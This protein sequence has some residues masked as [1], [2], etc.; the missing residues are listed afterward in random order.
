MHVSESS[1]VP[2][3]C[4]CFALSDAKCPEYQGECSHTQDGVCD[5]CSL[6]EVSIRE[7]E[8]TLKVIVA[9]SDEMDELTFNTEQAKRSISAWKAHLLRAVNQD[10]A[11]VNVMEKLDENSVFLVQDWAMKFLPRKYRESQSDWFA[12]RGIPWHITVAL[13]QRPNQQLET[14]TFVHIFQTCSQDSDAVLGIMADVLTKLKIGMP[15]LESV[16]YRQDNAG[17]YHCASTIVGAKVVGDKAGVTLK[18]MDFS[19]PQGGKGA[20]DRK[21]AT[22]KSHMH[23]YLNEGNDIENAVQMKAAIE[24]SGGV[25]GVVVTLAEM[26]ESQAKKA[27]TLEGVSF[28]NN[29]QYE[30]NCLR[31]WRAYDIGP[32]KIISWSKFDALGV[33]HECYSIVDIG[34]DHGKSIHLPF[35]A[36]KPRKVTCPVE[37]ISSDGDDDES[38]SKDGSSNS[39]L[40]SCPEEGCVMTYQRHS[41]LEHHLQCGKHRR[42][43]EQE[44]LLDRAMLRYAYELEKGG[45]KVEE[46]GDVAC[47]S[48]DSSCDVQ[49]PPLSIGWA[50]KSSFTRRTRFNSNQ[51]DYL[52]KKFDIGQ[53]TGR[54]LDPVTVSKEMR[55]AKDSNGNRLFSM[56]EFLTAQQVQSFFSRLASKR[57]VDIVDEEDEEEKISARHEEALSEMRQEVSTLVALQHPIMHD[58]YNICE[59]VSKGKL[60]ATFNVSVLR[61]ICVSLGIDVSNVTVKRK[62]PYID[63]LQE[64]VKSCTCSK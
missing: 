14:T 40:F 27:V 54:K 24:S 56:N 33:D 6:V 55:R 39:G 63:K 64:V 41:S 49:N 29:I 34:N 32:G 52:M 7:V 17:C 51:K 8:D 48:K 60:A 30:S 5:R 11:R 31:V 57:S 50:L 58:T 25:P 20:C 62:K 12:K 23:I 18:R 47:L 53:K 13:R 4:R 43:L 15:S 21:A 10:E 2:D 16:F 35:V 28:V 42:V 45:S 61:D 1:K 26:P 3:H 36:L 44:T 19:D 46:L 59:L 9:D 22:I 38:A 37:V